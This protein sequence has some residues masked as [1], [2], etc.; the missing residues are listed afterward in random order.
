[1]KS[2]GKWLFIFCLFAACGLAAWFLARL[3]E[4]SFAVALL[5]TMTIGYLLVSACLEWFR[6]QLRKH[7]T[8]TTTEER[9]GMSEF[10]LEFRYSILSQGSASP[11]ITTL[12]GVVAV[13]GPVIPLMLG[14][15]ALLKYGFNIQDPLLSALGLAMGFV[16]AWTWWSLGVTLWRWWAITRRGMPPGE[17]QWRGEGASLLWPKNHF[18]EKT[19][20]GN[21]LS[22]HRAR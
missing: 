16:L 20:L 11:R 10:D 14:P 8:N 22:K 2:F 19:E 5:I 15:L 12:I 4:L 7:V 13:N 21:L 18:L 17:V 3:L 1:M 6:Y 9:E